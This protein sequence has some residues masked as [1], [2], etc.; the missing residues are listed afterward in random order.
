MKKLS[1]YNI[2]GIV[3]SLLVAALL[4]VATYL[5]VDGNSK[6][7]D[8]SKYDFNSVIAAS[9]DNGNIGD[10]VK[11]ADPNTAEIVLVEYADYQCPGCAQL[12]PKLN[13]I[14]DKMPGKVSVIYR[15]Y[16]LSYHANGTAAAYA[17]EAAGL[18]G[19]W[20]EYGDKLFSSQSEWEY[21]NASD[22]SSYFSQYF[23]EVSGGKG[24]LEKFN[25]DVASEEVAKKV[26]FDMSVGKKVHIAGTPALYYD[27]QWINWNEKAEITVNGQKITWDDNIGT[28]EGLTWLFQ[29]IIDAKNGV[30]M[31]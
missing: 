6:L 26:N 28:E 7:T 12:N 10:H 15:S 21:A 29:R 9:E 30:N 14:F 17:A 20:K 1:G 13:A 4:G 22:R 2:A 31:Y 8:F 16:L 23:V 18:Q 19:Y 25:N 27:G 3:V 24:D 5:V 11:G